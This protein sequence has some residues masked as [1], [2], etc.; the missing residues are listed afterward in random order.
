MLEEGAT[1]RPVVVNDAAR[2]R[3]EGSRTRTHIRLGR[4]PDIALSERFVENYGVG[5][6]Y[7]KSWEVWAMV[8]AWWSLLTLI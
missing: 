3:R 1:G 5:R 6:E 8:G 4:L 2:T 7:G